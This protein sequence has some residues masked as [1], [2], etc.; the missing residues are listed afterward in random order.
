MF[1]TIAHKSRFGL[2]AVAVAGS[3]LIVGCG[4]SSPPSNSAQNSSKGDIAGGA[5]HYAACMRDHGVS[6]F[7]DPK[8]T[9]HGDSTAVAMVVP[10]QFASS[11]HFKTAESA[12]KGILPMPNSAQMAAQQQA[13]KQ[14]MLDFTA[15][16]RNHGLTGFPDPNAQ[17]DLTPQM[18]TAAG[19]DLHAPK[20]LAAGIA[21][22]PSS[23]GA[24]SVADIH[25]AINSNP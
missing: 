4:S 24:V 1:K 11:P 15:C 16:L 3:L 8:V 18:L 5:Y 25:R 22:V 6:N 21:C 20:V 10:S 17:G 7:P 9:Q 2:A 12:C 23:H 19:I 14:D 13:H